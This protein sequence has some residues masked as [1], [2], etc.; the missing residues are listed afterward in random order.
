MAELISGV[1]TVHRAKRCYCLSSLS[2][3]GQSL[4]SRLTERVSVASSR[5]QSER[6]TVKRD[7]HTAVAGWI[8]ACMRRIPIVTRRE[9]Q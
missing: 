2:P 3:H 9:E 6:I 5:W 4:L 1:G 8:E 7:A